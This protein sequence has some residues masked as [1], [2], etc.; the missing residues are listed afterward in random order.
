MAM[1][2]FAALQYSLLYAYG[3]RDSHSLSGSICSG[4]LSGNR[5]DRCGRGPAKEKDCIVDC[6]SDKYWDFN[7]FKIH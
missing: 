5:E 4:V 2:L 1:G 7:Y 6:G 3:Q